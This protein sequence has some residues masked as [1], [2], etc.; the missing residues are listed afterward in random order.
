M[1]SRFAVLVLLLVAMVCAAAGAEEATPAARPQVSFG[2]V[3]DVQYADRDAHGSRSYRASL[4]KLEA[5][6]ADLNARDLDFT[7]QLGDLIDRNP[8]SFDEVL[9]RYNALVMPHYSVLGNHD[10]L[11]PQDQLLAKLGMSAPYY[12]FSVNGWSFVV[13]DTED[14]MA[15]GRWPE[16]SEH[17]RQG[18][19]WV[20]ELRA[21]GWSEGATCNRCGVGPA[22]KEWLR[23][24]L[25]AIAARG[26]RAI[27][28]GHV[29]IARHLDEQAGC[30][31]NQDEIR[32]VLE[33]PGCV[34]AYFCGHEHVGDYVER[35]GIHYVIVQGMIETPD[36][37]AY[38]TVDVYDDRLE[39]HGVGRVPSR[40]LT[41]APVREPVAH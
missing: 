27:V 34:A 12:T 31:H 19:R 7:I 4:G 29:G 14:V 26:E 5:C 11:L 40:T 13:L 21:K 6:V 2:V 17:H 37:T 18:T 24:T 22:E 20:E 41:L 39:V 33:E 15:R 30:I 16:D 1:R 28:F 36:T 3:A 35:G 10:F 38:A 23:D 25:R 9:P 8:E 32:Q